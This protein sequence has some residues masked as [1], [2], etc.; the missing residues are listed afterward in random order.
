M[1]KYA[2]TPE[3]QLTAE[4]KVIGCVR[5]G[6]LELNEEASLHGTVLMYLKGLAFDWI[7]SNLAKES[8]RDSVRHEGTAGTSEAMQ[9]SLAPPQEERQPHAT[10]IPPAPPQDPYLGDKTPAF[11]EWV[12]KFHPDEFAKRYAGRKTPVTDHRGVPIG[13]DVPESSITPEA[14][15]VWM[16][17]R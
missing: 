16:K 11:M 14:P 8:Q 13:P 17:K 1:A 4:G 7:Q 15:E 5:E 2:I 10:E 12:A 3:G 6:A 9:T